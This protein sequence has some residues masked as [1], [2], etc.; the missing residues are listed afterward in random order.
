MIDL[1]TAEISAITGG[2][3]TSTA[4]GD[5]TIL[6]VATDSRECAPGWLFVAKPGESSDGHHFIDTALA[7]GAVLALAE[8]ETT[9][10]NGLVHPAIIVK[11]AVI[12]MGRIAAHVVSVLKERNSMR[13]IGITGSAGKTTTKDLLAT[14]LATDGETVAPVGSYNGEVGVPLTVFRATESTKYLVVEMG[15]TGIGHI[16]YLGA[17]VRPEIGVVLCVGSAHAGEF[18]SPENT[19]RAKGEL[20]EALDASG[21]AILNQDDGIVAAMAARSA[22]PVLG[23]GVDY[24]QHGGTAPGISASSVFVN[25]QG[26]PEFDLSFPGG[27]M[28]HVRAGLIGHHHVSNLLAA[29]AAAFAAGIAPSVIA[30]ALIDLGPGSRWRMERTERTDGVTIINDAYNANPQSMRAALRA[31][32]ELGLPN[33][34]GVARRTWAVLGEMLELGSESIFEHDLLG[35]A[36]VRLNIKK[37]LVVG[38]GAKPAYNSAVLEGSWGDEAYYV[39]NDVQAEAMLREHLEPGDIVLFKSS[40]GAGLRFLGDRIASQNS[41]SNAAKEEST[42]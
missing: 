23:F 18:G 2:R 11:D 32:A 29:A 8:R 7:A 17:M 31:L 42:Q 39:E 27:E 24:S 10:A 37:L 30:Q 26:H 25:A 41:G 38:R 14:I 12:A 20:V 4:P 13:V 40:N 33:A 36:A 19:A 21:V 5:Q 28:H 35:R 6:G 1:N 15:A 3:P 34:D 16:E 22:A 9:D